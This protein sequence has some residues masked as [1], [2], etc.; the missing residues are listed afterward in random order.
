MKK[1]PMETWEIID[2]ER[3]ELKYGFRIMP[4][5]EFEIMEQSKQ[6]ERTRRSEN[7]KNER[8]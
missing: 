6:N 8:K 1:M 4:E 7:L 5:A 2:K 3:I